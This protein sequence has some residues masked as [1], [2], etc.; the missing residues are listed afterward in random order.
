MFWLSNIEESKLIKQDH[1]SRCQTLKVFRGTK[2]IPD[3]LYLLGDQ[4][5]LVFYY[6]KTPHI[7]LLSCI[8]AIWNPF[9]GIIWKN[10]WPFGPTLTSLVQSII[11][12]S[13]LVKLGHIWINWDWFW[14]L[15][16]LGIGGMVD[17]KIKWIGIGIGIGKKGHWWI[18]GLGYRKIW[19]MGIF[20]L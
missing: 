1:G 3:I 10:V 20:R 9:R 12:R 11:I 18:G 19:A 8:W 15:K 16:D 4:R 5:T 6:S 13:D 2:I 14:D 17:F 7:P